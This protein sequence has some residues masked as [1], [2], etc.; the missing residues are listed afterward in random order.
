MN[1]MQFD[2]LMFKLAIE[3]DMTG[4][5]AK[6]RLRVMARTDDSITPFLKN[7]QQRQPNG[8]IVNVGIEER[9]DNMR[10]VWAGAAPIERGAIRLSAREQGL[11]GRLI[12]ALLHL[13]LSA[14]GDIRDALSM[15]QKLQQNP[16][17]MA[18]T[19]AIDFLVLA[20][21]N[22]EDL[23]AEQLAL[24]PEDDDD[25]TPEAPAL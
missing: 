14:P 12:E 21:F 1:A 23:R 17:P 3:E 22:V 13:D 15:S 7:T 6:T 2:E 20:G 9:L 4:V 11:R 24:Y 19:E 25:E 16:H 8:Q 10:E 18:L 5:D